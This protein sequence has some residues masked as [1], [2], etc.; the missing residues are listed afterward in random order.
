MKS[1]KCSFNGT[2]FDKDCVKINDVV[3]QI[4]R[5]REHFY[6]LLNMEDDVADNIHNILPSQTSYIQHMY[7]EP[8]TNDEFLLAS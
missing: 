4:S 8:F 2:I 1:G 6:E 3:Q 5:W 7:D